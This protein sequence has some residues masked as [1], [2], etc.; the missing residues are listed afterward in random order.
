MLGPA[1]APSVA[2]VLI[3]AP[4]VLE[5]Q[6]KLATIADATFRVLPFLSSTLTTIA[7]P[8]LSIPW[9]AYESVAT[10]I[11]NMRLAIRTEKYE[12]VWIRRAKKKPRVK[13]VM[14]PRPRSDVERRRS[15]AVARHP[16]YWHGARMMRNGYHGKL[17]K[18]FELLHLLERTV[19]ENPVV[20]VAASAIVAVVNAYKIGSAFMSYVLNM[21]FTLILVLDCSLSFALFYVA[22][23]N[24]SHIITTIAQF[25]R[26]VL[27][28][29]TDTV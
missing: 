22:L 11:K 6:P 14:T 4:V 1:A 28:M 24:F 17:P 13:K 12:P 18:P 21:L 10:Y 20:P 15:A 23:K 16:I 29:L 9:Q 27:M 7:P 19:E 2:P 25:W 8:L 3:A 26:Q 5:V